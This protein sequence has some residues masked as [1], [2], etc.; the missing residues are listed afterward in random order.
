[1]LSSS[2]FLAAI[3]AGALIVVVPG[4]KPNAQEQGQGQG[5]DQNNGL[6]DGQGGGRPE[7][8][9]SIRHDTSRPLREITPNPGVSTREDFEVKRGNPDAPGAPDTQIQ[10]LPVA[11]LAAIGGTGF[12]GVGEGN[13]QF[14]FKVNYAPP[15]T[16]G[17]AGLT[18]FVQWV[19]P[20]FAIFDKAT[21][22][23]IYGPAAGN[24]IWQGFGGDCEARNDGDPMVQYD[25]LADRWV[26]SQFS[27][28]QGNYLQCVAVSKTSDATGEWHRYAFLYNHFP[29]YPKLAVWP[30]AY[31]MTFNMFGTAGQQF[32][33]GRVCAYDRSKMLDGLPATQVCFNL[34]SYHSFLASDLEGKT[35]PPAG[36]PNYVMTRSGT[37]GMNV[38]KFKPNFAVPTSSTFTGP[39]PI[40]VTGYTAACG[41]CVPQPGT[42]QTLDTLSDRL[43]YRLSYRNLGNRETMVVN[44]SVS[45]NNVVGVR[46]YEFAINN[47]TV[48]VRQQSTYAPNDGKYRW[49]GST[50]TDKLGNIALGFSIS[51]ASQKPSIR[52]AGRETT[53]PLNTLSTD[54]SMHD[55][56]G[57]Q[58]TTLGRW[59]DY[60]SMTIDP[61][62][63]CTFWYTTE[64][65]QTNGT[66]NWSTRIGSFK[67]SSCAPA[68]AVT[69]AVLPASQVIA[70]GQ[71]T[72]YTATVASQNGYNGSGNYSVTGLPSGASGSFSPAGFT[73]GSGSSTLSVTT[74][75][76]T[77]PGTYQ[78]T[79]TAK[80]TSNTPADSEV[81]TL[82]VNP[83]ATFTLGATPAS[84]TVTQGQFVSYDVTVTAQGG[85][86]GNGT[87]SVTGLPTGA[88][89][90]FSVDTY[91]NGN[92]ST[93]LTVGTD[94][95]TP[96]GT[97]PFTVTATDTTGA[98]V[99]TANLTLVVNEAVPGGFSFSAT[100]STQPISP[101]GSAFFSAIVTAQDGYAGSGTF[102]A[103]GFPSGTSG[104]FSPAGYSGGSGISTLTVTAGPSVAV[105]SY[106]L[107]IT[108]TD[109]TGTP[110]HSSTVML[111]VNPPAS[112]TVGASPSSSSVV[113]G[114]STTFTA[115]VTGQNGYEGSGNFSVTGLPANANG[116]FSPG[117][118]ANGSGQ[119]TLTVTTSASTPAG[120]Y[121]LIITATDSTG[122]PVSSTT[123]SLTVTPAAQPD[124]TLA[125]TPGTLVLKRGRSDS[126]N[127]NVTPSGGFSDTVSLSVTGLPPSTSA[128]FSPAFLN[129]GGTS[130][131]TI[132]TDNPA[133]PKGTFTLTITAL[134][135]PRTRS[136]TVTLKVQ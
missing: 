81:V 38:F 48:S 109:S 31:Y 57:S 102:S 20:S 73:S 34:A 72:T 23:R 115:S 17:E 89:G 107:T 94:S 6:G 47:F 83:P 85:Y 129:G 51:S 69:V 19:N 123:V 136:I 15:D 74:T 121:S 55:G 120:T 13:S 77:A 54:S 9:A 70:A 1:M 82:V 62:D 24:T 14:A 116:S 96:P 63:D 27:L 43:M 87:F 3:V 8:A 64:Y 125:A 56:T 21:G 53:D 40:A 128:S 95:S 76:A 90:L 130:T 28:R 16:V 59:G 67:F 30:D 124:F 68:P 5:P 39:T 11:P 75:A 71:S 41:G 114:Q 65:L 127:V 104:S 35:L 60:S 99:Q 52:F 58:L 33:G 79:I 78:V 92:G 119:S 135:G 113:Q 101:N 108:A 126:Y 93:Q 36:S 66:F 122:A 80:D 132:T 42:T 110:Q 98:P 86:A 100:P 12:D 46:W 111:V 97:Y 49:M 61:V 22:N 45:A 25:Q 112:F 84:R 7:W 2:K 133:T 44:H 32:T 88:Q 118:Y 18:Q 26:M 103:T 37:G 50:A 91:S 29:D 117:G 106:P 4:A 131:L 10:S 105:G 134:S